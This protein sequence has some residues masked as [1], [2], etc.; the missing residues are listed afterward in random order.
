MLQVDAA[1]PLILAGRGQGV[2]FLR[3]VE[4]VAQAFDGDVGLLE[5]L[6]QADESQERL[7]HAAGKHLEGDEHAHRKAVVLHDQQ[8]A[9]DQDG[10]GHD[11]FEAV[12]DD[13]VGIADLLGREAGGQVLG[14]EVAVLLVDVGFHL[15]GF[16]GRH[17]GDVFG[18]ER[19]V[20]RAEHELLVELVAKH[21]GDQEA[22]EGNGAEQADG[23][24][25]ELPAVGKH[26]GQK[27]E[28][29]G[30]IQHQRD[31]GAGDEFADGFDAVQTG[32]QGAG[33]AVLEIGQRQ[34]EQVPKDLAAQ[35]GIDAIAGMQHEVLA[36]PGHGAGEEHEHDQ[37]HAEHDQG[38]V[39]LVNNHLVDDDLGEQRCRQADQL[40]GQTGEQHVAPDGLV[41]EEF[42][43]EPFET[44]FLLLG[45]KAGDFVI[46]VG[47]AGFAGNQDE[48]GLELRG[49][50]FD[51]N[52][53]RRLRA[54]PE[55]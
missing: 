34:S 2:R 51:A 27:D 14:E 35:H 25:R 13:V 11:L 37:G 30:K 42:G 39:G 5:L 8:G 26:H 38:A 32:D 23:N 55:E 47:A 21:R 53:F 29:E 6:P 46:L 19:L 45:R 28:Q 9:D 16:H 17:A 7:A 10:Q 31:G 48:V 1:G 4:D 18:K 36:Q 49:D 15:Q 20:S 41:F 3:H 12:G 24:Q 43:D 50:F 44:E 33:R 22:D 40:D 54:G 52:R